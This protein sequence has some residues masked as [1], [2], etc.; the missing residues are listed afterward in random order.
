MK[1]KVETLCAA[2]WIW[3]LWNVIIAMCWSALRET[4]RVAFHALFANNFSVISA[5][6]KIY[7]W[8]ARDIS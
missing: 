5:D 7:V 6:V 8:D 4:V 2:I 3:I 1:P